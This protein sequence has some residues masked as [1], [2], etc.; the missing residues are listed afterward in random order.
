MVETRR[1]LPG[2]LGRLRLEDIH[3][4][5]VVAEELHF[6]RAAERLFLTSGALSRRVATIERAVGERLLDRTTRTVAMTPTGR[7]FA[8]AA[9]TA[10]RAFAGPVARDGDRS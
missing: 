8:A 2:S 4:F 1:A 6:G 3:A 9:A 7:H 10:L 5:L